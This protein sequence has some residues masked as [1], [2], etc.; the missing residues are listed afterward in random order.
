MYIQ[1][2][3]LATLDADTVLLEASG[4]CPSSFFC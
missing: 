2:K 4:N 1:P 3:I